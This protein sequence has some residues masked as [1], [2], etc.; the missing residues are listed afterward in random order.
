MEYTL[1]N[2]VALIQFD[3]GKANVVSPA[4]SDA[5]NECLDRAEADGAGAVLLCGR[6]GM[7]SAGFDLKIFQKSMEEGIGMVLK[8]TNTASGAWSRV[9]SIM[10]KVPTALTSKSSKGRDAARS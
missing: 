3:D 1:Q 7:F 8:G 9:D 4:F 2:N 10:L 5:M 6:E